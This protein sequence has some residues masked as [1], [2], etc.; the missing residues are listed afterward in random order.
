MDFG[1]GFGS[2][3][4]V[5]CRS[6]VYDRKKNGFI[7]SESM[8]KKM[9]VEPWHLAKKRDNDDLQFSIPILEP[10]NN[11]HDFVAEWALCRYQGQAFGKATYQVTWKNLCDHA[12]FYGKTPWMNFIRKS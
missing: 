7:K 12:Q 11:I 5:A 3:F 1:D 8:S 4:D 6:G 9:D 10:W 2:P